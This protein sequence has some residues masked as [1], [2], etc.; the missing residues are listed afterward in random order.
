MQVNLIPREIDA[1]EKKLKRGKVRYRRNRKV[2]SEK[3]KKIEGD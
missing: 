3:K 1:E 2:N